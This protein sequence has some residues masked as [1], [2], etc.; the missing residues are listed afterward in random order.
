MEYPQQR[1][2]LEDWLAEAEA[3]T[4]G[5]ARPEEPE[6]PPII[7]RLYAKL[8]KERDLQL[9]IRAGWLFDVEFIV[10]GDYVPSRG[11]YGQRVLIARALLPEVT[12]ELRRLSRFLGVEG[13]S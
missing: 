2:A 13:A 5:A 4:K 11:D 6:Q 1:R 9:H 12:R 7:G 8:P 3:L 10:I